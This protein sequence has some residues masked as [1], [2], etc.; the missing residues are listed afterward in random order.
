MFT[1]FTDFFSKTYGFNAG[2]GGLAY[3]GLGV[4]FFMSTAFC[5][6]FADQNYNHVRRSLPPG[7]LTSIYY[8]CTLNSSRKRMAE[9]ASQK[10]G[11]LHSSLGHSLYPSVCC[12]LSSM[13][14]DTR[15]SRLHPV[16]MVGLHKRNSTGSC[17]LSE[18]VS[19]VS[20]SFISAPSWIEI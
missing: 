5:A 10:C 11:Y 1:T 20:V 7:S 18:Q 14:Q 6:R 15:D 17:R 8:Q 19:S 9:L 4:G 12:K 2:I 13:V 3:I 16:G